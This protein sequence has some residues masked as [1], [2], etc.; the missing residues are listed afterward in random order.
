LKKFRLAALLA[1]AFAAPVFAQ[2]PAT[3]LAR[4]PISAHAVPLRRGRPPALMDVN[5]AD[6]QALD[7]LPGVGVARAKAIIAGRP[8]TDKHELVTRKIVPAR[9]FA[10]IE[11]K[12]ALVNVNTASAADMAKVLPYVGRARAAAIVEGRLYAS[13]EDMVA[14]GAVTPGVFTVIKEL[15]TTG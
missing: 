15:V 3:R 7:A 1:L 5:S 9:V 11:D 12:I 13:P 8:Y 2:P 6:A 10:A 14:K 4:P